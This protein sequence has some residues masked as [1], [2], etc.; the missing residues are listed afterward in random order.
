MVLDHIAKPEVRKGNVDEKWAKEIREFAALPNVT[1]KVSGVATEVRDD[2]W[3]IETVRPYWDVVLESFTP[4]RLMFGSDWPVCLLRT[5]YGR[6]LQTVRELAS[7]LSDD[8][9][10]QIFGETAK[11]AYHLE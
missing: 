2:S 9:Q 10:K 3:D 11:R 6:W 1:C 4:S 7:P 8:E 5:E